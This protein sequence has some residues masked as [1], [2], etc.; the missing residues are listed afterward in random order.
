MS[1]NIFRWKA[2]RARQLALAEYDAPII[3]FDTETTG[4]STSDQVIEL[5]AVKLKING[6]SYE[7]IGEFFTYIKPRIL[8]PDE[9]IK[10]HGIRNEFL[11]DKPTWEECAADI[12]AFFGSAPVV[13]AYNGEFDIRM[14][15]RM[16]GMTGASF[17]PVCLLDVLQMARDL[18][19]KKNVP[20]YKLSS[21]A[22]Y[23]GVHGGLVFHDARDDV[24]AT[25][26]CMQIL[27]KAY[28]ENDPPGGDGYREPRIIKMWF[29]A[30]KSYKLRRICALTD[31]GRI[32][33][34]Q[35][36]REWYSH[37][38]ELKQLD[39]YSF[40]KSCWATAR[41]ANEYEFAKWVGAS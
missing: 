28:R 14:M 19:P 21:V 34:S 23:L 26:G 4:V 9:A 33:F 3:V 35:E 10:I 25:I 17:T 41:C 5:A 38:V 7:K 12:M 13:A 29:E 31:L 18:I 8:V 11:A 37:D 20:N 15:N 36:N 22:E 39:M 32:Y 24:A 1:D 40:E 2:A 6:D 27:M 16:Y 30:M